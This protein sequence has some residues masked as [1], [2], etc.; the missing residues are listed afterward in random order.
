MTRNRV[1]EI[2]KSISYKPEFCLRYE[3]LN[4]SQIRIGTG[5]EVLDSVNLNENF[6]LKL[7][8]IYDIRSIRDEHMFIRC[9]FDQIKE[10]E[11]HEA[12]EFFKVDGVAPFFPH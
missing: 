7:E 5:M 1:E 6:M 2:L 12:Q 11:L 10:M 4:F 9:V 8:R 3:W